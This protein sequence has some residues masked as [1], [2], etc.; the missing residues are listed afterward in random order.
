MRLPLAYIF[1]ARAKYIENSFGQ[2][3]NSGQP[4]FLVRQGILLL[5]YNSRQNLDSFMKGK[6]KLRG[7]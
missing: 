3:D 4:I 7:N 5:V 1:C 2:S 6:G